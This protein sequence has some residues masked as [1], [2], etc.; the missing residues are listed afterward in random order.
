MRYIIYE[1]SS[2]Q[3]A[4]KLSILV[5][6]LTGVAGIAAGFMIGSRA[7]LFDGMYSFVDVVMTFGALAVSKLCPTF[8]IVAALNRSA[9]AVGARLSI[10]RQRVIDQDADKDAKQ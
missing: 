3:G 2:E 10:L 8:S 4:L 6:A 5:T 1:P 9:A 7:I